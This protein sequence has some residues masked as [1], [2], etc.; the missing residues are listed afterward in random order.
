MLSQADA[1]VVRRDPQ[2]PG[3]AMLLDPDAFAETLRRLYP[4]AGVASTE[5][6]Y[7][8]YKPGT[9]CLVG[10]QV[11]AAAG[12]L[13]V[14][15]NAYNRSMGAKIQKAGQRG[16]VPSPLGT[17]IMVLSD[18]AV[19]IY[20][21]P[22]D[23]NLR[24]LQRL[25]D[26]VRR[27][28][29]MARLLPEHRDLWHAPLETLHY[30]P[31]RRYVG[32]L[33]TPEDCGAVLKF[34]TKEEF[35]IASGN[36]KHFGSQSSVRMG[37]RLQGSHR[38]RVI[39]IE[40][41]DG[42]PLH[43][44]LTQSRNSPETCRTVGAALASL[45]AQKP[46]LRRRYSLEAYAQALEDSAAAVANI[47]PELASQAGRLSERL[48]RVVLEGTW[49][50]RAIHGDFSADQVLLRNG[51]VAVL[52]FDQAGYGDPCID[53]GM[54]VARLLHAALAGRLSFD[55]AESCAAAFLDAYR[56]EGEADGIRCTS[57]FTAAALLRLAVEPFR[58]RHEDWLQQTEV[59]LA[60][61]QK[62]ASGDCL[63]DRTTC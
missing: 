55:R 13:D 51:E 6:R 2:L 1:N 42:L 20:P 56:R 34:Y 38:H 28:A 32:R 36:A 49:R 61:A 30:K 3:L 16:G 4:D 62:I 53:S 5:P 26:P 43:D 59:L 10:Y 58:H 63:P 54:F 35:G 19:V 60:H 31:E 41:L 17:G 45:H 40:W 12:P 29:L 25:G 50:A 18:V 33:H 14:Y 22:N 21:F 48:G 52:D 39:A 57:V 24:A 8:R 15:A 23:H 44:A 11:V 9:S 46:K 37:R 27:A 7:V 47:A